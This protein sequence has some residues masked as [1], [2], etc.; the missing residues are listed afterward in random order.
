M[1]TKV[2]AAALAAPTVGATLYSLY[3]GAIGVVS[4]SLSLPPYKE[5]NGSIRAKLLVFLV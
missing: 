3:Q 5:C 1:Q 4:L 2:K